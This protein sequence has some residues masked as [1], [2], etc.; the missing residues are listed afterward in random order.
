MVLFSGGYFAFRAFQNTKLILKNNEREE[1]EYLSREEIG[2]LIELELEEKVS[3]LQ[4][5]LRRQVTYED[6]D[7]FKKNSNSNTFPALKVVK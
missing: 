3:R 6:D 5:E 2:R 1:R 7:Y 4:D